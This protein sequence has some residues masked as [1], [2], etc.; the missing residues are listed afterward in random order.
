MAVSLDLIFFLFLY[1]LN[2]FNGGS[3]QLF[4]AIIKSENKELNSV[5]PDMIRYRVLLRTE[6]FALWSI[7]GLYVDL[8]A[9]KPQH[10]KHKKRIALYHRVRRRP[11]SGQVSL[12]FFEIIRLD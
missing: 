10:L 7:I 2:L 9:G 12:H 11:R 8:Y 4:N 6:A 5:V 3:L 1:T